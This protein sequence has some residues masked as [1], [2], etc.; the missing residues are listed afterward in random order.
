MEICL[1][2]RA[3]GEDVS[4]VLSSQLMGEFTPQTGPASETMM[5]SWERN[6][7]L[8]EGTV[9]PFQISVDILDNLGLTKRHFKEK[10]QDLEFYLGAFEILQ[11]S[12]AVL[13]VTFVPEKTVLTL[14][15]FFCPRLVLQLSLPI[16]QDTFSCSLNSKGI[17]FVCRLSAR[18][19]WENIS[20]CF[21][22]FLEASSSTF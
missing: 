21:H 10:I 19:F 9:G 16:C 1:D 18:P 3:E 14:G 13:L 2:L 15:P 6:P 12:F 5:F 4:D 8:L 17:A 11:H 20:Y 7:A 22:S